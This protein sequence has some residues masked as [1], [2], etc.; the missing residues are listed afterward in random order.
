MVVCTYI[1]K[2]DV[3]GTR[4]SSGPMTIDSLWKWTTEMV[5]PEYI[6]KFRYLRKRHRRDL[7]GSKARSRRFNGRM[8]AK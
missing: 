2:N 6:P 3:T 5:A 4:W 7:I 1:G 8:V